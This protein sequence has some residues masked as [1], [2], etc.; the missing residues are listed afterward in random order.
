MNTNEIEAKPDPAETAPKTPAETPAETAPK[1]PAETAP[2]TPDHSGA[3]DEAPG[4][5]AEQTPPTVEEQLEAARDEAGRTKEKLLRTAA[6]F[7]NFRKRTARE[8]EEV[9]RRGKRDAGNEL[10]PVLDS[11]ERATA[12]V[13]ENT[14]AKSMADGINMVLKQ[15]VDV[16]AKMNIQRVEA[17]GKPFDP[18]FHD[19][20]QYDTS[21]EHEAG[22]VMGEVQAGYHMGNDLLRPAMVIVSRGPQAPAE[23]AEEAAKP[24]EEAAGGETEA[25]PEAETNARERPTRD[26]PDGDGP[27]DKGKAPQ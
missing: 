14:N 3:N 24:P 7:D 13:D 16:I 19:S 12:H 15:F 9:R 20:I 18:A 26:E 17:V 5:D 23:A 2:K 8:V 27:D 22:I 11:I 10:L 4:D 1:T 21:D 25:S 6:D